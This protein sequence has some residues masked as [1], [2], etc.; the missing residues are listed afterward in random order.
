MTMALPTPHDQS[1][2]VAFSTWTTLFFMLL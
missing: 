1:S 2:L